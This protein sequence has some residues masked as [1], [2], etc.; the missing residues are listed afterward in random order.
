[1]PPQFTKKPA[2]L[3]WGA[4]E[5]IVLKCEV[6]GSPM[7][8]LSWLKDGNEL[9]SNAETRVTF[10]EGGSDLTIPSRSPSDGGIYQCFAK[11]EVG[12]IQASVVVIVPKSGTTTILIT[13]LRSTMNK[14][15]VLT[16]RLL[17]LKFLRWSC[18]SINVQ[19]ALSY[20]EGI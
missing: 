17:L 12:S 20:F 6:T 13:T 10:Y 14:E 3:K 19:A 2:R 15:W 5:P 1:M 7:P 18:N 11:N 8:S 16:C 4:A 9:A